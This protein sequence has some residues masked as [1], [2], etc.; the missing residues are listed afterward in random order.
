MRRFVDSYRKRFRAEPNF[1][2]LHA[3]D[4]TRML[5]AALE[6]TTRRQKIRQALLNMNHFE[7]LQS[8]LA[9]D[10]YGDQKT[11]RLHLACIS[12]GKFVKVD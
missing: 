3:Y 1:P 5:F 8:D 9:F 2:A 11:P 7:S 4:A 6:K 10:R 12:N